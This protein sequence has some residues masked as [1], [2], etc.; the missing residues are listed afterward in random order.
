MFYLYKLPE[1]TSTRN[2]PM[3]QANSSSGS[4]DPAQMVKLFAKFWDEVSWMFLVLKKK[5]MIFNDTF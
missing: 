4:R 3:F 5:I 2:L 1:M